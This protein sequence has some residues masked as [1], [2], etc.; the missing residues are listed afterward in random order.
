ME[1]SYRGW[2]YVF[3]KQAGLLR[4]GCQP[5]GML[6]SGLARD[7]VCGPSDLFCGRHALIVTSAK[8]ACDPFCA[9]KEAQRELARFKEAQSSPKGV[10]ELEH[11]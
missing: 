10:M 7:L 9:F 3:E 11:P 4:R 6:I 1:R 5:G 8:D 2:N